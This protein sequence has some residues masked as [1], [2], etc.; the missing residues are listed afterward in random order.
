[1]KKKNNKNKTVAGRRSKTRERADRLSVHQ[2]NDEQNPRPDG[3]D[4]RAEEKK[5]LEAVRIQRGVVLR[6]IET[7]KCVRLAAIYIIL[8]I[9]ITQKIISI[10]TALAINIIIIIR[11][12]CLLNILLYNY[13]LT[14]LPVCGQIV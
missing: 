5:L 7:F 2:A 13:L 9:I 14:Y 12:D 8:C 1:M 10:S 4:S 3:F 11:T 6:L